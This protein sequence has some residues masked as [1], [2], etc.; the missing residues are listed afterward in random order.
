MLESSDIF[1]KVKSLLPW[2]DDESE[3]TATE[4]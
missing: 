3:E 2:R 4:S 1:R